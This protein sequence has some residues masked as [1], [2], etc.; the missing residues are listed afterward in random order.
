MKIHNSNFLPDLRP[1]VRV[2]SLLFKSKECY[3]PVKKWG[4]WELLLQAGMRLDHWHYTSRE[5]IK[6][7]YWQLSAQLQPQLLYH[8]SPHWQVGLGAGW[9]QPLGRLSEQALRRDPAV[10]F[11]GQL[12]YTW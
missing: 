5:G 9:S 7:D 11:S 6:N 10:Q 8:L 4:A 3:G 1:A 2:L 12:L